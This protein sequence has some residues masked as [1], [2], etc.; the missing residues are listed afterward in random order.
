[1]ALPS[2][3]KVFYDFQSAFYMYYNF[4]SLQLSCELGKEAVSGPFLSATIGNNFSLKFSVAIHSN[5]PNIE[6]TA[7]SFHFKRCFLW[8]SL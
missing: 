5:S 7:L 4:W 2:L 3:R 8:P 1:M 6:K